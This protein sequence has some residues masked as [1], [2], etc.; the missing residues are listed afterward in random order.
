M[1]ACEICGQ[2]LEETPVGHVGP[3]L[4]WFNAET[5]L[6]FLHESGVYGLYVEGWAV[7]IRAGTPEPFQHGWIELDGK[8]IDITPH[9][10]VERGAY[11][12]ALKRLLGEIDPTLQVPLC[13]DAYAAPGHARYDAAI[14]EAYEAA[15]KA[16]VTYC[17]AHQ[18][19][20]HGAAPQQDGGS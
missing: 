2:E 3:A 5:V 14:A 4:C 16:A 18:P 15:R 12:P 17:E 6:D 8:T 10:H 1:P 13:R 20:E 9:H 7:H 11:F 19:G